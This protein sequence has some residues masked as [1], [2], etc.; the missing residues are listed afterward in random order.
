MLLGHG[1]RGDGFGVEQLK[2]LGLTVLDLPFLS[3]EHGLFFDLVLVEGLDLL[4][5]MSGKVIDQG[6]R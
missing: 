4:L 2:Q 1:F 5:D 6:L 3:L